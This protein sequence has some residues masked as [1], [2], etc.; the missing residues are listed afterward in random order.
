M[1]V[2][3]QHFKQSNDSEYKDIVL[4]L[5][6]QDGYIV[7]IMRIYNDPCRRIEFWDEQHYSW[8]GHESANKYWKNLV[9]E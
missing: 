6:A 7:T 1:H 9:D 2:I 5:S 8:A 3:R 4:Q